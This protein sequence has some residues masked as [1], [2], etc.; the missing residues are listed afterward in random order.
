MS[1]A[2]YPLMFEKSRPGRRAYDLPSLDVPAKDGLL[3]DSLLAEK[4]PHLPELAEV[5]VVRH[6]VGLS[7]RNFGVDNG[8]YPLGSCTMKYNPKINEVNQIV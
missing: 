7:R 5:D 6:F 2:A 3:D 1:R 4:A 8:F